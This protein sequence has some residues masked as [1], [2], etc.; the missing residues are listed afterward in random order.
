MAARA[1]LLALFALSQTSH[2]QEVRLALTPETSEFNAIDPALFVDH[3]G[4]WH[5]FW[6]S[7]WTGIKMT[8]W[9][10]TLLPNTATMEDT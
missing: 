9:F 2:G 5:L 1:L 3:D 4:G 8:G 7:Y 10:I 6:G